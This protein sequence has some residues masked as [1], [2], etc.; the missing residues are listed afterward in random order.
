MIKIKY[1][2][3]KYKILNFIIIRYQKKINIRKNTKVCK[4]LLKVLIKILNKIQKIYGQNMKNENVK[5]VN[6]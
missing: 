5:K 1:I 4:K 6:L 2:K 3:L